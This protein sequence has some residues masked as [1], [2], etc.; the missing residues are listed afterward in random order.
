MSTHSWPVVELASLNLEIQAQLAVEVAYIMTA[1]HNQGWS[2]TA[3]ASR[4]EIDCTEWRVRGWTMGKDLPGPELLAELQQMAEH[5]DE[6]PRSVRWRIRQDVAGYMRALKDQGWTNS[7]IAQQLGLNPSTTSKYAL[8]IIVPSKEI[9][10]AVERLLDEPVL[11]DGGYSEAARKTPLLETGMTL[12]GFRDLMNEK[13]PCG[14][15]LVSLNGT[16][17]IRQESS[18]GTQVRYL[19][20]SP[21]R[22]NSH[23]LPLGAAYDAYASFRGRTVHVR[24]LKEHLPDVYGRNGTH[25]PYL[26]LLLHGM[27]LA[28]QVRRSGHGALFTTFI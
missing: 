1:L 12:N 18:S 23:N 26:F 9:R 21:P 2:Y 8:G 22:V 15:V 27:G 14:S 20:G 5:P 4:P 25:G 28:D 7:G 10:A 24:D 6:S 19:M 17:Y 16:R 13:V 3:I 11:M